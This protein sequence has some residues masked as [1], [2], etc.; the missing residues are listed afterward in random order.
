MKH[1]MF[2]LFMWFVSGLMLSHIA[3]AEETVLEEPDDMP[4]EEVKTQLP[5]YPENPEWLKFTVT[6]ATTNTFYID[7]KSLEITKD[8]VVH[9]TMRVVSENG[10]VNVTREGMRCATREQ[11]LYA[12]GDDRSK[13]W[14]EPHNSQW[15][16]FKKWAVNR[17]LN[18]LYDDYFC[19]GR[20][21]VYK[22][23]QS[24]NALRRG[25]PVAGNV[26]R[27]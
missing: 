12:I 16:F 25:V 14:R 10:A 6:S 4:W 21:A 23:E 2:K 18:V 15:V 9:Y 26:S 20:I 8:G 1:A 19:P 22:V 11:K 3:H 24:I 5:P 27:D 7:A 17:Q 13:T